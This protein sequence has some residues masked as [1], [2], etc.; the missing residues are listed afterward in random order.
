MVVGCLLVAMKDEGWC[1]KMLI[2]DTSFVFAS[3]SHR[4]RRD[5]W[6]TVLGVLSDDFLGADRE[7]HLV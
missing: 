6:V 1:E 2:F 3:T 7:E 4:E 5:V